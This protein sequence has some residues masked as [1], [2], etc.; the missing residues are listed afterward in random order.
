MLHSEIAEVQILFFQFQKNI[1][2]K[3]APGSS[4]QPSKSH[5][6]CLLS[7]DIKQL[8]IFGILTPNQLLVELCNIY[9][10]VLFFILVLLL[11]L[12]L[13]AV[14]VGECGSLLMQCLCEVLEKNQQNIKLFHA[15]EGPAIIQQLV[16]VPGL[17][18]TLGFRLLQHLI[19]HGIGGLT[20][21]G[22]LLGTVLVEKVN[23]LC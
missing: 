4:K 6:S 23:E 13:Q 12:I 1:L 10:V 8:F 2:L 9:Q 21:M 15:N 16:Y 3:N 20:E 19:L 7:A 14:A 22:D 11:L 18:R 5:S 17:P